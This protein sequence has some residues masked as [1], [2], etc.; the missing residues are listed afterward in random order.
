MFAAVPWIQ[1]S[2]SANSAAKMSGGRRVPV[3]EGE[4]I[5]LSLAPKKTAPLEI[6]AV[7]GDF[8]L[9]DFRALDAFVGRRERTRYVTRE[10][11]LDR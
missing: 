10:D 7:E 8:R 11:G 9:V 5:A 3:E 6:P 2:R 4:R 1:R